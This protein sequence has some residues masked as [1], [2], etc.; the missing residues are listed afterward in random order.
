MARK[1][2]NITAAFRNKNNIVVLDGIATKRIRNNEYVAGPVH[3][4]AGV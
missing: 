1:R 4:N 2:D 3:F